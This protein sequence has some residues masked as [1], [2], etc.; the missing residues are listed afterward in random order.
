MEGATEQSQQSGPS[1][2]PAV[3]RYKRDDKYVP[4]HNGRLFLDNDQ[5]Q[6][7]LQ[8]RGEVLFS[9]RD[10]RHWRLLL[11]TR[12]AMLER[13]GIRYF[14]LVP[15]NAH[16]VYPEDLPAD[17]AGG[18]T[19]P[20]LQLMDHLAE[21][22]SDASLIYPLE[23]IVATKP[24]NVYPKNDP[25]WTSIGAFVAFKR[26]VKDVS[27]VVPVHRLDWDDV[28]FT[29]VMQMGELGFKVEPQQE[30]EHVVA[31]VPEPRAYLVSDNQVFNTGSIVSTECAHA[32]PTSCL[33]MGDSFSDALWPFFAASF[34]QF[35][36]AHAPTVDY[37]FVRECRPDVVVSVLNERFMISIPDDLGGRTVRDFEAEK[38]AHG[39]DREVTG[40]WRWP[41]EGA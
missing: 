28:V 25:H 5:N 31:W 38:K 21:H 30:A 23:E 7:V 10:L 11:E 12:I 15:P 33:V 24:R 14:F 29:D 26:L 40:H 34:G 16:A 9:E 8:H 3:P 17:A 6:V 1:A 36:F 41:D 2:P 27:Q 4:G 39:I 35:T 20:I 37:D 13:L 32:P 19:R 22:G 18:E